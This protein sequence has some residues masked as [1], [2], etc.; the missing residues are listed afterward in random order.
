MANLITTT[1]GNFSYGQTGVTQ[2]NTPMY[3]CSKPGG[4]LSVFSAKE[5]K[6]SGSLLASSTIKVLSGSGSMIQVQ[7]MSGPQ[8][9]QFCWIPATTAVSWNNSQS[10]SPGPTISQGVTMST[11]ASKGPNYQTPQGTVQK[12]GVVGGGGIVGYIFPDG[13]V[14]GYNA[15]G[16][17][18]NTHGGLSA[19]ARG[20]VSAEDTYLSGLSAGLAASGASNYAPPMYVPTT[21]GQA[22]T[23]G[24]ASDGSTHAYLNGTDLGLLLPNGAQTVKPTNG[25]RLWAL[26]NLTSSGTLSF[27][28]S[29]GT[30]PGAP[31]PPN[32]NL[33][34]VPAQYAP[35][36]PAPAPQLPAGTVDPSGQY[37]WTG[38]AWVNNPSYAPQYAP[39]PPQPMYAPPAPVYAPTPMYAP[40]PGY[41]PPG[42]SAPLGGTPGV[43]GYD[44]VTGQ[45]LTAAQAA[46][47]GAQAAVQQGLSAQA[48]QSAALAQQQAAIA[49]QQS[50]YG[51]YGSY[52]YGASTGVDPLT[53]SILAGGGV[54][55]IGG[56]F[57]GMVG[58]F[59]ASTL[60]SLSGGD[61]D[62][63]L[64]LALENGGYDPT[65]GFMNPVPG[66]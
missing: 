48:A 18:S 52:G 44:P 61:P 23:T 6:S 49:A 17:L 30:V 42:Y 39:P 16:K 4:I 57:S 58:G 46:Y 7:L 12:R 21:S 59:D 37:V 26:Y 36:A 1:A 31:P 10:S 5:C 41:Y 56:D 2:A 34:S 40:A 3:P 22:W 35:P 55:S 27:V 43:P 11:F 50:A 13:T 62:A 64:Q 60:A 54:S 65:Q 8:S 33:N 63:A 15:Q 20:T 14:A 53:A 24:T 66:Y 45:P 28:G 38:G 47:Q 9:G 29:Y 51:S 25:G 32:A 19:A